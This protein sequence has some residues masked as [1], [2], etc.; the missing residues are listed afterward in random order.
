MSVTANQTGW[1]PWA[2]TALQNGEQITAW[3]GGA[4]CHMDWPGSTDMGFL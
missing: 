2:S 4:R 1:E 3:M